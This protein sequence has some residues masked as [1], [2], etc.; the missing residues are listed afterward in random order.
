MYFSSKVKQGFTL[1]EMLLVLAVISVIASMGINLIV[2][3]GVEFRQDKVTLQLQQILNAGL[4][5]YIDNGRWPKNNADLQGKYLPNI[6]PI[7]PWGAPFT[8]GEDQANHNFFVST[9]VND[10]P[11]ARIIAGR[12]PFGIANGTNVQVEVNIPGQNLN[13][14]RS[15]NFSSVYHSGGCV[16]APQCPGGTA[17]RPEIMVVPI[18]VSG[19]NDP[20]PG[21]ATSN[22]QS[23]TAYAVGAI[24][25]APPHQPAPRNLVEDCGNPGHTRDCDLPAG[26]SPAP[27]GYWRV[28]ARVY[29]ERGQIPLNSS[30]NKD[31]ALMAAF[32][33]CVPTSEPSGSRFDVYTP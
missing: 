6:T 11:T 28:C 24:G 29:T 18:S 26:A 3:K 1:L 7:N 20:T 22:L 10:A 13:N 32:T 8:I 23:F 2:Q 12:L 21:S 31:F 14:A 27:N 16:P 17:M 4:A 30:T 9:N 25:G 19:F 33:R 5:Y 15:I